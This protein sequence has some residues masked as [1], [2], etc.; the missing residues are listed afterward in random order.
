MILCLWS[1]LHPLSKLLAIQDHTQNLEEQLWMGGRR[2]V[3]IIFYRPVTRSDLKQERSF[4][5]GSVSSFLQLFVAVKF[6]WLFLNLILTVNHWSCPMSVFLQF[7]TIWNSTVAINDRWLLLKP[8][9][10]W[11]LTVNVLHLNE[12]N[13]LRNTFYPEYKFFL[14]LHLHIYIF[15]MV[16]ASFFSHN[17]LSS[18][19]SSLGC[20]DSLSSLKVDHNNLTSLEIELGKMVQLEEMVGYHS[21]RNSSG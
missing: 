15:L 20:L 18:L 11:L 8:Y 2:E 12:L 7:W 17:K 6:G 9:L 14:Y 13:A 5:R 21:W 3:S 16:F 19:P 1:P 4:F 10:L